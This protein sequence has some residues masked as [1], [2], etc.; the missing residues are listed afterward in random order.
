MMIESHFSQPA[1]R[2]AH[3]ARWASRISSPLGI[4]GATR[5]PGTG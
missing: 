3:D 1:D 5:A 2:P 4:A